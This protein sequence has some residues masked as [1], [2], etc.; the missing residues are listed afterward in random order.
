MSAFKTRAA[1]LKIK[2][3]DGGG[4]GTFAGYGSVFGNLDSYRDI[5]APGAFAKSLAQHAADGT[6]VKMLWQHQR[7]QPIGIYTTVRED[8]HGLYVEGQLNMDVA[9]AQEAYSLL[10][11]GALD[12]MSIGYKPGNE[13]YDAKSLTNTIHDVDILREISLVTF[14]A[15][16][17]SRVLAVKSAD[18]IQTLD[19]V[20]E[21]MQARG[22]SQ[23]EADM[24]ASR[25]EHIVRAT[26]SEQ[27]ERDR[28]ASIFANLNLS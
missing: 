10:K 24:V 18:E 27:D 2:T 19:Q 3:L 21:Y 23:K 28:L 20:L 13:T 15:N 22:M 25:I 8:E 5:V 16:E 12:G 26:K 6:K 17:T 14:P 11:Q 4:T 1:Q 9:K 7:D